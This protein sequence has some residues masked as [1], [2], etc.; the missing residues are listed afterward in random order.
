MLKSVCPVQKCLP[1]NYYQATQLVSKLGLKVE[2]IDCCKNGCML[3]YKDDSKLSECKFCNA[4][5]FIP[6]KTGMGKYKDIPKTFK[7]KF[8]AKL[9]PTEEGNGEVV[10]VLDGERVN[11]LWTEAAGGVTVVGFMA[12]QI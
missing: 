1:E 8:D 9:Q 5:R 7:E 12:L 10:R 6:R 2:K 3:Y 11:Q 4:P